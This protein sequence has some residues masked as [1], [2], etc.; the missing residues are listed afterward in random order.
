MPVAGQRARSC[1]RSPSAPWPR[2]P[3]GGRAVLGSART[4]GSRRAR[5]ADQEGWRTS[6]RRHRR[7][8][9]STGAL[10]WPVA[11][12][13]GRDRHRRPD[14]LA[15]RRDGSASARFSGGQQGRGVG[16]RV[17]GVVGS[18]G[19][20]SGRCRSPI[21]W[22]GGSGGSAVGAGGRGG[23]WVGGRSGWWGWSGVGRVGGAVGLV[24]GRVV[25]RSGRR[26][27]PTGFARRLRGVAR[28]FD[29]RGWLVLRQTGYCAA[30]PIRLSGTRRGPTGPGRSKTSR[31]T[32][33]HR[34][35]RRSPG[36]TSFESAPLGFA[37]HPRSR[38]PGSA[39]PLSG[40]PGCCALC[41]SRTTQRAGR[42]FSRLT[43]APDRV[44]AD[45]G[46]LP[47]RTALTR[48]KL[49]PIQ[50]SGDI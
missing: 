44:L 4:R 16:W 46:Q 19:G 38:R 27:L 3:V 31:A 36:G 43:A 5:R 9:M 33:E 26:L 6:R 37:S 29:P 8:R 39:A 7:H 42:L 40:P 22:V 30:P 24:V 20:Q 17:V 49:A 2:V 41:W 11:P 35:L 45:S 50:A 14:G 15:G 13:P 28:C 10:H 34:R 48:D 32:I 21:R 25:G 12:G 47:D 18:F 1:R 23:W